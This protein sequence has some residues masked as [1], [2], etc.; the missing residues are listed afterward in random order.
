MTSIAVRLDRYR[1]LIVSP[2]PYRI[3]PRTELDREFQP[4][5]CFDRTDIWQAR[6]AGKEGDRMA[7]VSAESG[8][9]VEPYSDFGLASGPQREL[10]ALLQARTHPQ[11][12]LCRRP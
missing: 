9:N 10:Q 6:Q 2:Q 7:G 5:A 8:G 11:E 4:F 12:A 1:G 3:A